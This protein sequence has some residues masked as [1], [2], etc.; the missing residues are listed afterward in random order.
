VADASKAAA[1]ATRKR[2]ERERSG[3]KSSKAKPDAA[4][5]FGAVNFGVRKIDSSP[6][7]PAAFSGER[8]ALNK[9]DKFG[10]KKDIYGRKKSCLK[11]I[12]AHFDEQDI[13]ES[14]KMRLLQRIEH[15]RSRTHA[16]KLRSKLANLETWHQMMQKKFTMSAN[17]AKAH[18][19]RME[20]LFDAHL[21]QELKDKLKANKIAKRAAQKIPFPT[22]HAE[23]LKILRQKRSLIQRDDRLKSQGQKKMLRP[24]ITNK[25]FPSMDPI[26]SH[27]REK[28]WR[29]VNTEESWS[30]SKADMELAEGVVTRAHKS[31]GDFVE[32]PIAEPM[33]RGK[34][35]KPDTE[36]LGV[37]NFLVHFPWPKNPEEKVT[38]NDKVKVEQTYH[39]TW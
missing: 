36:P 19:A 2:Q 22:A 4:G 27:L 6:V 25:G 37:P 33:L 7:P 11:D 14:K 29:N 3:F 12:A 15:A 8:T 10:K 13:Y 5:V 16:L 39:Q 18:Q 32:G 9:F 21:P 17:Q 24:E 23:A 28:L 35:Y 31:H 34:L 38:M 1:L 20:R 30:T 26:S